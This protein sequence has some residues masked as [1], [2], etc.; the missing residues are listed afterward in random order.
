MLEFLACSLV[1]ILPD[2]LFRRYA[3]GKRIGHEINIFSVWYELRWGITA[4]L[5]LTIALITVIFFYH[6]TTTNVS[7][8]F[9]T[10]SILPESTGRVVKVYVQNNQ[11]VKAGDVLFTLDSS[12][13]RATVET[14]RRRI[15]E[16]E[17]EMVLAKAE[18]VATEGLIAK[19][20]GA[21]DQAVNELERKL[22]LRQRNANV[23]T[24]QQIDTLKYNADSTQGA[25][26]AEHAGKEVVQARITTQLPA[27]KASAQA[28]L[29]KA[30]AEL[31]KMTVYAGITGTVT[32]FLLQPGDIVTPIMRPA[33]I[34]VPERSGRGRFLAGFRQVSAPV[35]KVG[36]IAEITCA[37]K[38]FAVIPMVVVAIQ[39]VIPSGQFRPGDR[40]VDI[41]DLARPGTILVSMDPL[42]EGQTDGILPGSKCIANAYTESH[43][44]IASGELSILGVIYYHM[45]DT[46][47]VVHALILRMQAL[48]L[49][50]QLLVFSGH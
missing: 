38:P 30:E 8:L 19:A 2:F 32:Q 10:V 9:R 16:F 18:L 12:V 41:Q 44:L 27:Q 3:Q 20:K 13:Q 50:V 43:D 47:G 49:P 1:T 23:V 24:Q 45:V 14:E 4:C 17:A 33:G 36:M 25:L 29:V 35:L 21:H 7:S 15:K 5:I 39:D 28:A 48:V 46:L 22:E 26:K 34:L 42:Y 40:L 37:S 31:A 6:P 11:K